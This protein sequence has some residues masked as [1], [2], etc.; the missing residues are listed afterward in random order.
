MNRYA[1][2]CYLQGDV[3]VNEFAGWSPYRS[4]AS[5]HY[6]EILKYYGLFD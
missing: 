6:R 4:D 5:T 1:I 3:T 2:E